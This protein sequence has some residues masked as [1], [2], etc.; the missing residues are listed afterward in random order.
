VEEERRQL[1]LE[2]ARAYFGLVLA[3]L[4]AD[5][6]RTALAEVDKLIAVNRLRYQQGEVSGVELRRLEVERMK[7]SDDVLLAELMERNS[8]AT[9]L[10]FLGAGRLDAPLDPTDGFGSQPASSAPSCDQAQAA[11]D[12]GA[13]IARALAARADMAAAR[14]EQQRAESEFEF[15]RALRL[16]NVTFGAGYRRDFGQGGLAISASVPLPLFDRNPG[17]IARADAERLLA[18]RQLQQAGRKVS[19]EVQL[20]ANALGAMRA[21][22]DSIESGYLQKAKEARDGALSAYRSGATDLIDYLDAQRAYRDVQRAY[23]RAQFDVR[24]GQLQLDAAVGVPPGEL[25]P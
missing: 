13:L 16:P 2:A 25:R 15:Q 6:A 3:R 20:A 17:G 8:R 22:L 5:N 18:G 11:V 24:V 21:R 14:S 7:F 4:E 1:R 23:Q 12:P 19:L 9:L 10:S